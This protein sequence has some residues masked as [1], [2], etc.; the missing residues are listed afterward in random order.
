MVYRNILNSDQNWIELMYL[1]R[2]KYYY[3]KLT[4]R[5]YELKIKNNDTLAWDIKMKFN[6]E[7]VVA[8][9]MELG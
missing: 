6:K 8:T 9:C 7:E 4:L 1:T 5:Q 2:L 3:N